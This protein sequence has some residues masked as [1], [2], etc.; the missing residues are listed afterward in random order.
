VE[1]EIASTRPYSG[2][3]GRVPSRLPERSPR[4]GESL[5]QQGSNNTGTLSFYFCISGQT[6]LFALTCGHIFDEQISVDHDIV[7]PSD[8][9][10]QAHMAYLENQ[11]QQTLS[12]GED[13][14][15]LQ[16]QLEYLEK[17]ERSFGYFVRG[18]RCEP[19]PKSQFLQDVALIRL[20]PSRSPTLENE[21]VSFKD[22][23]KASFQTSIVRLFSNLKIA[24]GLQFYPD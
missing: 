17:F 13:A 3:S 15:S 4:I 6:T 16:Q 10:H 23:N 22:M 1:V 5:G 20:K 12:G 11:I 18:V 8:S 9:D 7:Q 19:C 2:N 21:N 24:P 14:T